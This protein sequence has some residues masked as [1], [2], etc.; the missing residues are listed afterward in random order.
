MIA[1]ALA[2]TKAMKKTPVV[3]LS[4][5]GFVVTRLFVSY[6]K[7]AFWLL[8]EGAE[9]EA[10]DRAMTD[11]GLPMGP[12]CLIDMS[13]LDILIFTEAILRRAFPQHGGLSRIA[14]QLVGARAPRPEDGGR[15]V[16]LRAGRPHA[17]SPR[18]DGRDHGRALDEQPPRVARPL[19][20]KSFA[21]LMLRMVAEAFRLI[22]EGIVERPADIDVAMVLGTGLA[23]F[24]GGVLR[25]AC[26][27]GLERVLQELRQLSVECGPRYAPCRLL[28]QAAAGKSPL[29]LGEG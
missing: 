13:G 23:D 21:R 3:V 2:V 8:E 11:F 15:R 17:P 26:D 4:R 7:E 10:V 16:S 1:A 29:P 24:R 19:T 27:L 22:E 6:L 12:L 25:Y 14:E 9:P 28:E 18:G 20:S 5:E